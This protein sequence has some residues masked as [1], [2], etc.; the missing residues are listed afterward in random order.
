MI[1][2]NAEHGVLGILLSGVLS[3]I[4]SRRGVMTSQPVRLPRD[5]GKDGTDWEDK[6]QQRNLSPSP[7]VKRE[8]R[9][10]SS[11]SSICS[12]IRSKSS[13]K[14]E[15]SFNEEFYCGDVSSRSQ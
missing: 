4:K 15:L 7:K 14:S 2:N 6:R 1:S 12:S 5:C 9:D 10:T 11:P 13:L 3:K 8:R